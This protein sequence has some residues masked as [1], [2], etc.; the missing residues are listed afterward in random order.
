MR[1]FKFKNNVPKHNLELKIA[2]MIFKINPMATKVSKACEKFV[3][4]NDVLMNSVNTLTTAEDNEENREKLAKLNG[5]GCKI[6]SEFIDSVLGAGSYESLFAER[7]L[8]LEENMELV[9]FILESL[10]EYYQDIK[11]E[12]ITDKAS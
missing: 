11:N 4:V 8:D 6:C 12:R 5:D 1:E 10:T 7:T 9:T 2:D 3:I